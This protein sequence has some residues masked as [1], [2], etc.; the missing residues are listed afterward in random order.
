MSVEWGVTRI[1]T[2]RSDCNRGIVFCGIRR[3]YR[4]KLETVVLPDEK[5]PSGAL[6]FDRR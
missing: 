1:I 5:F 6:Y 2:F 4:N 3:R